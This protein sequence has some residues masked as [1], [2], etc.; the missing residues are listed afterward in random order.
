MGQIKKSNIVSLYNKAGIKSITVSS[1][2]EIREEIDREL[3]QILNLCAD[4]GE[5]KKQKT[6]TVDTVKEAI[7]LHTGGVSLV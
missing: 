3:T 2:P 7:K 4:I 1:L 6:I 5:M